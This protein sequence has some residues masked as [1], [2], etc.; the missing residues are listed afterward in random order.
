M[1]VISEFYENRLAEDWDWNLDEE[2]A[3]FSVELAEVYDWWKTYPEREKNLPP[4]PEPP[5]GWHWTNAALPEYENHPYALALKKTQKVWTE[6][7]R[8]W[9]EEENRY[10]AYAI[11]IRDKLID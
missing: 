1:E 9:E 2:E 5:E 11:S 3:T 4:P 8:Q 7:W 10:L 6:T